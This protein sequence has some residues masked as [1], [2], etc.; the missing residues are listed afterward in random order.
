MIKVSPYLL[1]LRLFW[2]NPKSVSQG[3]SKDKLNIRLHKKYF[4]RK[5]EWGLYKKW[6]E[7]EDELFD[8]PPGPETNS[9]R[10]LRRSE[11]NG[12]NLQII[13]KITEEKEWIII[14]NVKIPVQ[15]GSEEEL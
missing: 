3:D 2:S 12:R 5:D 8:G 6:V 13:A 11:I 9:D 4:A 15:L 1:H 10:R 14:E 7:P